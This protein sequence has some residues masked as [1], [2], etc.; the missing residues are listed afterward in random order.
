MIQNSTRPPAGFSRGS[1]FLFLALAPVGIALV[2][3]VVLITKLKQ[4]KYS[5][6]SV[7]GVQE[8]A[9]ND[10]THARLE[11]LLADIHAFAD[12]RKDSLWMD[13][14]DLN[15]LLAVSPVAAAPSM[16]FNVAAEDSLMIL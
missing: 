2:F 11:S 5:V 14:G 7:A 15:L 16:R 3:S 4:F 6:S 10:S 12:R 1:F 8:F 9:W 13:A